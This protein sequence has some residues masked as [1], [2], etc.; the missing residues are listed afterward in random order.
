[1]KEEKYFTAGQFAKLHNLNKRTLQYYDQIG[2]FMP[3]YRDEKDY[4]YYA[5]S[6]SPVL[7]MILGLRELGLPIEQ[8]KEKMQTGT[9][10]HF[11]SLFSEYQQSID[12]KI[13]ELNTIKASLRAKKELLERSKSN[14]SAIDVVYEKKAVLFTQPYQLNLTYEDNFLLFAKAYHELTQDRIF[15]WPMGTILSIENAR[16]KHY[17]RYEALF[18]ENNTLTDTVS[19]RE[20]GLFLVGYSV[21]FEENLWQTY[22]RLLTYATTHHL[23][24]DKMAYEIG[25]ND[26]AYFSEVEDSI[27]QV[28]IPIRT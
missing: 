11:I 24:L 23:K 12:R 17:D 27:N 7:E 16:Q 2:L 14:I 19:I 1:M 25:L 10:D 15:R 4:R 3:K 8:I 9:V 18:L 20:A 6:Q 13:Q 26:E 28:M 21:G 5:R 22:Q